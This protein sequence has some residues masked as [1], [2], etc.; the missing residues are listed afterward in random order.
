MLFVVEFYRNE[1]ESFIPEIVNNPVAAI[2]VANDWITNNDGA[3]AAIYE[4]TTEENTTVATNNC[5]MHF[6]QR[7]DS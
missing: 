1:G 2:R 5:L 7:K 6:M 4:G 3:M